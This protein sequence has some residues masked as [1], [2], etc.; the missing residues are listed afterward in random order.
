MGNGDFVYRWLTVAV[1]LF[2]DAA[3]SQPSNG[4]TAGVNGCVQGNSPFESAIVRCP[5]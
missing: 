4:F 3:C 5:V 1:S 2:Y